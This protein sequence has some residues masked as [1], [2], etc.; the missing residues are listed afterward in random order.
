MTTTP[1]LQ[2]VFMISAGN[3][4]NTSQGQTQSYK[5]YNLKNYVFE[6]SIYQYM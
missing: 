3:N 5:L 6:F 2:N 4:K 1:N